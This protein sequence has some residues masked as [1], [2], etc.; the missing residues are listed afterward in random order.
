MTARAA[1]PSKTAESNLEQPSR[2][3]NS[4]AFSLA[5]SPKSIGTRKSPTYL[6]WRL[7]TAGLQLAAALMTRTRIIWRYK[8]VKFILSAAHQHICTSPAATALRRSGNDLGTTIKYLRKQPRRTRIIQ[9]CIRLKIALFRCTSA[10]SFFSYCDSV[11]I[12]AAT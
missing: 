11:A 2:K 10:E 3:K 1:L 4:S 12:A 7:S 9:R 5:C 6:A 8:R